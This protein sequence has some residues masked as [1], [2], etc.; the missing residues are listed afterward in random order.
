MADD[1]VL[2][3]ETFARGNE[4]FGRPSNPDFLLAPGELLDL[5][6]ARLT[7]VGFEQGC[8][9]T[10]G[11][12]SVVQR[13]AAVGRQRVWPPTLAEDMGANGG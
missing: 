5:A 1:G 11:R 12:G 9:T 2:L 6:A 4:V 7:V 13:I 8:V 10:A 3:Y